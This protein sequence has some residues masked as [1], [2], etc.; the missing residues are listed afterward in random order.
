MGD[1]KR[2]SCVLIALVA[3]CSGNPSPHA[4]TDAGTDADANAD[5]ASAE[6]RLVV[7]GAQRVD[8][9]RPL[10]VDVRT[11]GGARPPRVFALGLPPGAIW[12]EA[13]RR[14]SF[15]PDFTQGGATWRVTVTADDGR[16]RVQ[17]AFDIQAIDT[18]RPPAPTIINTT[19]YNDHTQLRLSQVTDAF[20]DSPGHAG[21]SFTAVVTVPLTASATQ[22]MPV[23]V[24]LHGF[25]SQPST[26]GSGTE[27]RIYP[28][29]PSD[30]YWWGYSAQQPGTTGNPTAGAVP[31]YTLRRVLHLLQWVLATY[32]GADPDRV[33]A[34][35]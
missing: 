3:G 20:L 19:V 2:S 15:T 16:A 14:L 8:E 7:P 34:R 35:R 4:G 25:S 17:G 21:R 29:D 23:R 24:G 12:D 13:Q 30:T 9:D 31:D 6:L 32:P 28:A 10:T 27:F 33:Y 5:A 18:I 11:E 26:D 22:R 1:T